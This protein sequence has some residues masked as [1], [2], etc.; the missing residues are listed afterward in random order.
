MKEILGL[1]ELALECAKNTFEKLEIG[2]TEKQAAKL[3]KEE[4][5]NRGVSDFFHFPFAWFGERTCFTGLDHS[6]PWLNSTTWGKMHLPSMKNPLP[7]FGLEY[8]PS[9]KKL[10]ENTPVI[11]DVAPVKNG[12][13]VD[14]G[15]SRFF[16]E[17]PVHAQGMEFLKNLRSEI[18]NIV[19]N[20]MTIDRIYLRVADRIEQEG[21]FNC[22]EKYPLSVLG[23]KVG[24]WTKSPLPKLNILGFQPEAFLGLVKQNILAP[25]YFNKSTPYLSPGVNKKISNGLWAIEPHIGK[26]NIGMKFE[27]IL[28]IEDEQIYWLADKEW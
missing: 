24:E 5:V 10:E 2:I 14:I 23:H 3:L 17:N 25:F 21:Y 9:D 4:L 22:H 27:E 6:L 1:Q 7:H 15:Y 12:Q 13:F 19:K 26:D 11:L 20:E 18:P 28:V 8:L 16:G